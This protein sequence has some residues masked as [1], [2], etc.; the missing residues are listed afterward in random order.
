MTGFDRSVIILAT[1]AL[2]LSISFTGPGSTSSLGLVLLLAASWVAFLWLASSRLPI[3]LRMAIA[4]GLAIGP[5][6][7]EFLR[8][9]W[10]NLSLD[11]LL[12]ALFGAH[13]LLYGAPLLWAGFLGLIS[14]RREK[15]AL[16]RLALAAIV[17]GTLGLLFSA[18]PSD[19]STRIMTWAPFL[20]PGLAQCFARVRSFATRRPQ[21]VLACAGGL[22]VLWNLLFMEQY[23]RRLLPSDDTVSFAEVTSNSAGLLSRTVGTPFAWPANW[24][25]AWRFHAPADRWDAI[26]DRRLF[27]SPSTAVATIEFGDDR[28]AF[29]P[30]LPL[31]LEGF[32]DRR[33]CEHGWCRDLDGEGRLLLP[34]REV[35]GD[36]TL[37][38][39]ARGQGA[40]RLSLNGA[41]TS[42]DLAESLSDVPLRVPG[43]LVSPG[44]NILSLSVEGGGKATLDRLT[45]ERDLA[46][47][48]AR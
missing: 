34:L 45:L 40:L 43:R 29:A 7:V 39:R 47:G 27:A 33:T 44:V 20:L 28:S 5:T 21:R 22:M 46:S 48:S 30:D 38:V 35:R 2:G 23:R 36:L 31:L 42:T 37:L 11:N 32:G 3:A 41:T 9:S 15:P 10:W 25:F 19:A 8:A 14:L 18:D 6:A 13:G 4:V 26:A 17:P 1:L 16:V 12:V 24:I